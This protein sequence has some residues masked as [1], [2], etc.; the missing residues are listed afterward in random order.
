MTYKLS[1]SKTALKNLLK[2]STNK[3][4]IILEK[5]ELLKLAPY[6][7]NNNIKK[8]VGYEGYRLRVGEYRVIYRIVNEKLEVLVINIDVRG[9]IYK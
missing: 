9:G 6:K 3:R 5:L 1:F 4:K 2:I 7:E 8:L